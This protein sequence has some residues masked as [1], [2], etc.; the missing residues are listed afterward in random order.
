MLAIRLKY[1][2]VPGELAKR[3]I[4]ACLREICFFRDFMELKRQKF[5]WSVLVPHLYTRQFACEPK[6]EV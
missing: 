5:S 4:F 3:V 1:V 2:N 6:Q